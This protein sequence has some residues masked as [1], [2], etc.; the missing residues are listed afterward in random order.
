MSYITF[1]QF[2]FLIGQNFVL[3]TNNKTADDS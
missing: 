2:A 3:F 1:Q